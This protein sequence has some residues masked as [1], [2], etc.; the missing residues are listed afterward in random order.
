MNWPLRDQS[1][2]LKQV[3]D[4]ARRS[5]PQVITA[6]GQETAVV[7]S[8]EDYHRLQPPSESLADFLMKSPLRGSGIRIERDQ[9]LG[10][11]IDL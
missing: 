1:D 9:N 11:D 5:G 7:L 6:E 10:R 3:V 8:I 2:R 4:E